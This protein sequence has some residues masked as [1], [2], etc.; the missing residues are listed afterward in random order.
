M[1]LIAFLY[2]GRF[3][4]HVTGLIS[5]AGLDLVLHDT[6]LFNSLIFL[7]AAFIVGAMISTALVEHK[8][9]AHAAKIPR[10]DWLMG[11]LF[12]IF[13]SVYIFA[14]IGGFGT[15][16]RSFQGYVD[17]WFLTPLAL[18]SGIQNALFSIRRG[19]AIRTT[20]LTG[21]ATDLAS[22]LVRMIKLDRSHEQHREETRLVLLRL[23]SIT[24]FLIGSIFGSLA[25]IRYGFQALLLPVA[26]SAV[27]F[28]ATKFWFLRKMVS[29][30]A[31]HQLKP[32]ESAHHAGDAHK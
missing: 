30:R 20:H 1:N 14:V 18:A 17:L 12:F 4:T 8:D 16:N 19:I 5:S 15:F 21:M 32:D 10:Y 13:T 31:R 9:E 22:G 27:I 28:G 6:V 11:L 25:A 26:S 7:F 3:I 23:M 24:C 29:M 2:S